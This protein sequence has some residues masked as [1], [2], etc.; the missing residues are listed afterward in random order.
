MKRIIAHKKSAQKRTYLLADAPV[1][2]HWFVKENTLV[3]AVRVD[4]SLKKSPV[5]LHLP[6]NQTHRY[7]TFMK[8][9]KDPWL[10]WGGTV[11]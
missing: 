5:W 8:G 7:E 4:V 1:N 6:Q 9:E 11:K 2:Y 3:S 10:I